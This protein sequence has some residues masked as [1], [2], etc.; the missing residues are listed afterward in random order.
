MAR[1]KKRTRCMK[2]VKIYLTP[3]D[4]LE[5]DTNQFTEK[6]KKH[7]N[8]VQVLKVSEVEEVIV[9]FRKTDTKTYHKILEHRGDCLK[10]GREFCLE[11]F[12]G[13]LTKYTENLFEELKK[14][15]GIE[16]G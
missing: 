14:E 8:F 5:E 7:M 10:W 12:G 4:M 16:N 11:C 1:T 6:D 2:M 9:A 3:I 13:G 15:L